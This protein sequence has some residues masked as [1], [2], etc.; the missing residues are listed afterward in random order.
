MEFDSKLAVSYWFR[1]KHGTLNMQRMPRHLSACE[2]E[3]PGKY[4]TPDILE[5]RF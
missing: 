1:E 2:D 5:I 3:D 4:E